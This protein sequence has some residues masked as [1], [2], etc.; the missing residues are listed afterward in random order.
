[1]RIAVAVITINGTMNAT[2]HAP[3][4]RVENGGHEEVRDATPCITPTA[5]EGVGRADNI[6]VEED[7]GPDLAGHKGATEDTDE[8]VDCV[9]TTDTADGTGEGSRHGA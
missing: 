9:E 2:R 6:L 8:E 1:M 7:R 5:G 4:K 3:D